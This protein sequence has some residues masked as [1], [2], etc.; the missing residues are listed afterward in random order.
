MVKLSDLP[1]TDH[2]EMIAAFAKL[3]ARSTHCCRGGARGYT[4]I[5]GPNNPENGRKCTNHVVVVERRNGTVSVR[6]PIARDM[7][8]SKRPDVPITRD[9][10]GYSNGREYGEF[11][12]A[13]TAQTVRARWDTLDAFAAEVVKR[14]KAHGFW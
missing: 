12:Y 13:F 3:D 4:H 9:P 2:N 10:R 7:K 11:G 1:H 6:S 8:A 5:H 14:A